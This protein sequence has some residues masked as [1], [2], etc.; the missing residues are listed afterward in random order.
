M[1]VT[2]SGM[3]Y[4]LIALD[5]RA[6]HMSVPVLRKLRDLVQA[7]AVVIGNKPADTPSLADDP[8][9]FR[10][11][12]DEVWGAGAG[13][14]PLGKGKVIARTSIADA[15]NMLGIQRD[16]E[17]ATP[18]ADMLFVHRRLPDGDIYYVDNRNDQPETLTVTF[19]VEGKEA[20]LWHAD[21]GKSEPAS[22][23]IAEGR[24]P[25]RWR[26]A[27][28]KRCSSSSASLRM[29]LGEPC[30]R[31]RKWCLRP[32]TA[33]WLVSFDK[34]PCAPKP[35][36]FD[37][38]VS[39]SDNADP[40]VKYF[41]G[42]TTYRKTVTVPAEWL[43]GKGRIFV[44][45]GSVKNLAEVSVNGKPL[46]ILWK[47]PF[48][49]DVTEALRP[50]ENA[51]AIKVMDLWVNRLIGDLQT[52]NCRKMCLHGARRPTCQD[53]RLPVR[54]AWAGADA[55]AFLMN[56]RGM[57]HVRT[58]ERCRRPAF[59]GGGSVQRA[60]LTKHLGEPRSLTRAIDL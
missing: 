25:C 44:D 11:L 27:P 57:R 6:Q 53:R 5:P 24:R 50:G 17:P 41:S 12:A 1:V 28:M 16:F 46:G 13:T 34:G 29:R 30:R 58:R 10:R 47:E 37:R 56:V 42:T 51:L 39:W 38:L 21:S 48:R 20:E 35:T 3:S 8:V 52:R 31:P 49:V 18:G 60:V 19:R 40:L 32:S 54:P 9:E 43:S 2:P 22:Y 45:L 55:A 15:L 33:P 26:S 23:R 4:R 36:A 59:A 14:H 7:G